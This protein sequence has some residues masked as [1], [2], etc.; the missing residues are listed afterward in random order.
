MRGIYG[1]STGMMGP[2]YEG[3]N[4]VFLSTGLHLNHTI[5]RLRVFSC[6]VVCW[7]Y[8]RYI[9]FIE[10]SLA[11]EDDRRFLAWDVK[12]DSLFFDSNELT[13]ISLQKGMNN[14]DC[15]ALTS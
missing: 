15:N 5:E 14:R 8:S 10:V 13:G 9:C 7:R 11:I 4:N 6:R 12:C 1:Q 2:V 3:S